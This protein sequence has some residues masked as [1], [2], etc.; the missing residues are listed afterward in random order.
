MWSLNKHF[1]VH[2]L[3]FVIFVG[4][5]TGDKN[6]QKTNAVYKKSIIQ[7]MLCCR[8]CC[9]QIQRQAQSWKRIDFIFS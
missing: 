3:V 8:L 2:C 1:G 6:Q 7:L 9:L 4:S 5:E